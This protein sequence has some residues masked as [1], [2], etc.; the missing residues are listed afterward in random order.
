MELN[1]S[2]VETIPGLNASAAFQVDSGK[3]FKEDVDMVPTIIDKSLSYMPWRGEGVAVIFSI[4]C[5]I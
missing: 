4:K 1:F 5:I 2:S 3:V